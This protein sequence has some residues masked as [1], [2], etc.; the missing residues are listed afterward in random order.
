MGC[1]AMFHADMRNNSRSEL[2]LLRRHPIGRGVHFLYLEMVEII[3]L[4]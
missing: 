2:R 4:E 3:C 1:S